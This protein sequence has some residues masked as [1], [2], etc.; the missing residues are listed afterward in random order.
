[1][2][3]PPTTVDLNRQRRLINENISCEKLHLQSCSLALSFDSFNKLT[4]MAD[5]GIEKSNLTALTGVTFNEKQ[6]LYTLP[7]S[8]P[9]NNRDLQ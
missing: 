1:M 3:S 4:H 7:I 5:M 2:L 8:I 9:K 6:L